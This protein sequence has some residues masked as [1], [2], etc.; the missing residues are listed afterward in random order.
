MN[1]GNSGMKIWIYPLAG[2]LIV[3]PVIFWLKDILWFE[4]GKPLPFFVLCLL[5]YYI[6]TFKNTWKNKER[7]KPYIFP[8]TF[9]IFAFVALF[10]VFFN[11][12]VFHYGYVLA[13]P[14]FAL[15]IRFILF[16]LPQVI[17]IQTGYSHFFRMSASALFVIY[18]LFHGSITYGMFQIKNHSLGSGLDRLLDYNPEYS[19]QADV[20]NKAVQYINTHFRPEEEYPVL[21]AGTLL[22]YLPRRANP[23]PFIF[24]TPTE[25]LIFKESDYIDLMKS[26]PPD[27]ILI[28]QMDHWIFGQRYF[29]KDYAKD[30]NKWIMENYHR[31]MLFGKEP[32]SGTLYGLDYGIVILKKNNPTGNSGAIP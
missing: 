4:L 10:K 1:R 14:A 13:F 27:H 12:T 3:G 2:F 18:I 15:L 29:G 6:F 7:L 22:N 9:S 21:P 31:E 19:N 26:N 8:L 30:L 11:T 23:F 5:G 28:Q 20:I 16:E 24:F 32:F 25:T 17:K